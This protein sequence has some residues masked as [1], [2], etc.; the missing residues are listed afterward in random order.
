MKSR[1]VFD[2]FSV[3]MAVTPIIV[4]YVQHLWFVERAGQRRCYILK[5]VKIMLLGIAFILFGIACRTMI[6]G[7]NYPNLIELFGIFLPFVGLVLVLI[8]FFLKEPDDV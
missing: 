1:A 8:G 7:R 4:M 6:I 3:G 2:L 5:Q